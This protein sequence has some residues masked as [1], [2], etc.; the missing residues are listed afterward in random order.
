[1][2]KKQKK[3]RFGKKISY[4]AGKESRKLGEF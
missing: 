3:I 2:L 4:K 1:M